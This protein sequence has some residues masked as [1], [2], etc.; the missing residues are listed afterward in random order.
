MAPKDH[1]RVSGGRDDGPDRR[2]LTPSEPRVLVVDDS[3]E[4]RRFMVLVLERAGIHA[5]SAPDG[6]SAVTHAR[7]SPPDVVVTDFRLPGID[8]LETCRLLREAHGARTVLVSGAPISPAAAALVD[9][10]LEKP[11]RPAS[12]VERVRELAARGPSSRGRP[13]AP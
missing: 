3:A 8:G 5:D 12:L 2:P 6:E 4:L 9:A 7:E 10:V 11:F 13:A 1:D